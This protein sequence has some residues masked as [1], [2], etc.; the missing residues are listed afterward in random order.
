MTRALAMAA[1]TLGGTLAAAAPARTD[2]GIQIW[3]REA[4][5][6]PTPQRPAPSTVIYPPEKN[7][8]LFSHF[9][10]VIKA[11]ADCE[12]CHETMDSSHLATDRNLPGHKECEDC[13]NIKKAAAGL[14]TDPA[15]TCDVC[16]PGVHQQGESVPADVYPAVNLIF[17]HDVHIAHDIDCSACHKSISHETLGSRRHLMTMTECLGCHDGKK[18]PNGCAT[19][20]R[21]QPDGLLETSFASGRLLPDGQ[22]SDDDHGRDFLHRHAHLAQSDLE[23]CSVCHRPQECVACHASSSPALR[24]HP[25]DWLASHGLSARTNALDCRS[26]HREQSFCV[27]CHQ[28]RGVAEDSPLRS[29]T[30]PLGR[31]SFHPPG[32]SSLT[33]S[34]PNHHSFYAQE[35]IE[36]CAS[37]HQ[38][39]DCLKCHAADGVV[40]QIDPHPLGWKQSGAACRAY[41]LTPM[42]CAKCHGG[43]SNLGSVATLL[44]GCQ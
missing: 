44:V 8:L 13:H 14:K 35:N 12:E 25:P 30:M 33:R 38:E 10:H 15:S 39:S 21:T 41:H 18:A 6:A 11:Q 4:L 19:C 29:P 37:C 24:V 43:G 7:G 17:P 3:L 2:S 1:L 26:C 40:A 28:Q 23:Q 27:A 20:H 34:G 42:A 31:T 22:L 16:H 36:A 5:S 32:W 9:I